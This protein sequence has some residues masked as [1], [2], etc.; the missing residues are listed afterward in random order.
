MHL[1]IHL[2]F[3]TSKHLSIHTYIYSSIQSSIYPFIHQSIHPHLCPSLPKLEGKTNEEAW[4]N[5][6]ERIWPIMKAT[7]TI[8]PLAQVIYPIHASIMYLSASSFKRTKYGYCLAKGLKY[9]YFRKTYVPVH[10][11]NILTIVTPWPVHLDR[12][13]DILSF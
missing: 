6:E 3:Y 1:T 4:G 12:S 10:T 5:V 8:W 9:K 13:V 2:S 7:W 11:I